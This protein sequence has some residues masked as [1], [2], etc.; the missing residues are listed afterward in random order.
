MS[1]LGTG[2][3][4]K[5]AVASILNP[6]VI[7]LRWQF[8]E[9]KREK[10]KEKHGGRGDASSVRLEYHWTFLSCSFFCFNIHCSLRC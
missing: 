5:E 10:R 1:G 3:R 4:G 9:K 2:T 8:Q 6:P 7:F